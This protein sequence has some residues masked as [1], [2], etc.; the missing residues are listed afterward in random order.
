M[1]LVYGAD[2]VLG[3]GSSILFPVG[4]GLY[5]ELC[6]GNRGED[7]LFCMGR[8]RWAVLVVMGSQLTTE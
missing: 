6:K 8:Q 2:N 3:I 1:L 7:L 4:V 5:L